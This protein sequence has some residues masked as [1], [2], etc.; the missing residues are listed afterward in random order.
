M[1]SQPESRGDLERYHDRDLLIGANLRLSEFERAIG[2]LDMD[3]GRRFDELRNQI[4]ARMDK[5]EG[6]QERLEIRIDK[7][8]RTQDIAAGG[9]GFGRW[10]LGAI[11]SLPV[12][13][14]VIGIF[15]GR[16]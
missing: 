11:V 7:V 9:L 13:A 6:T 4:N 12:L 14:T 10:M 2:R 15:I 16:T 8:E 1:P 3:M 5:L